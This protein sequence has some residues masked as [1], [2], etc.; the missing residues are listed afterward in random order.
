MSQPPWIAPFPTATEP[1]GCSQER[2]EEQA[3]LLVMPLQTPAEA[4]PVVNISGIIVTNKSSRGRGVGLFFLSTVEKTTPAHSLFTDQDVQKLYRITVRPSLKT[5]L[6]YGWGNS[7]AERYWKT[8]GTQMCNEKTEIWMDSA[9][10]LSRQASTSA[11]PLL[12][13]EIPV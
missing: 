11:L 8:L 6:N 13:R 5:W 9:S 12:H 1:N 2:S 10:S 3:L 7:G 4:E